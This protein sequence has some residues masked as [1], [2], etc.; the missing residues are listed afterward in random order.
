MINQFASSVRHKPFE[1]EIDKARVLGFIRAL[2]IALGD[3][4]V[5]QQP[6]DTVVESIELDDVQI[7]ANVTGVKDARDAMK[8]RK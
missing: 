3:G 2:R 7:K 6:V 4:V 5:D 8:R 1:N